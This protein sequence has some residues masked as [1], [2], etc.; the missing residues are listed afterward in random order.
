MSLI[1]PAIANIT[2]TPA[3][4]NATITIIIYLKKEIYISH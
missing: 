3:K 4:I 2:K 1:H